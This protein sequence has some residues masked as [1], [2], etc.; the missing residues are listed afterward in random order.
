MCQLVKHTF[1]VAVESL[2]GRPATGIPCISSNALIISSSFEK[3]TKPK[4]LDEPVALSVIILTFVQVVNGLDK[5]GGCWNALI[6]SCSVASGDKSPTKTENSLTSFSGEFEERVSWSGDLVDVNGLAIK[7][8]AFIAQ[9]ALNGLDVPGMDTLLT[10]E[11]TSKAFCWLGKVTKACPR[12]F[13]DV[14]IALT[15]FTAVFS[16]HE[17]SAGKSLT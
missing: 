3:R 9:S 6:R 12:L 13:V 10:V 7:C 11:R 8:G 5:F 17:S 1:G 16:G 4:H 15:Y 2:I 14:C